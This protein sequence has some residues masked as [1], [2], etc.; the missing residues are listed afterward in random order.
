MTGKQHRRFWRISR[1]RPGEDAVV[2]KIPTTHITMDRLRNL[3]RTLYAKLCLTEEEIVCAHI[4]ANVK[5]ANDSLA[6]REYPSHDPR[7]P[8]WLQIGYGF[9]IHAVVVRPG[10]PGWE[11]IERPVF[12]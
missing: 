4:R 5:E 11:E 8:V 12:Q 10:D 2:A 3:L 7:D 1:H 6:V 9:H